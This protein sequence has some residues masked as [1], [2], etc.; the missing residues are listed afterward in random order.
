MNDVRSIAIIGLLQFACVILAWCA[1]AAVLKFHGYPDVHPFIRWTP[2]AVWLREFGMWLILLVPLW[3]MFA[4]YVERRDHEGWTGIAVVAGAP[5][6]VL[7]VLAFGW[8]VVQP[9]TRVFLFNPATSGTH[10]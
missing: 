10:G 9:F 5:L 2:L 7:V 3:V 8:A 4:M 1:L 6:V